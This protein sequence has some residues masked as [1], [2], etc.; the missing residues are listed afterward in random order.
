MII[1][2]V[3]A[4]DK[5]GVIGYQNQLPWHLPADLQHFKR[6]T[7]GKPVVM[8]RKTFESLGKP[9]PGQLNIILSTQAYFTIDHPDCQIFCDL[10]EALASVSAVPEVMV[11]GGAYL[12]ERALP[13]AHKMYLT[14]IDYA[15][16]G[17]VFFPSW[18]EQEWEEV[19]QEQGVSD[20]RNQ[21]PHRFLE[22]RRKVNHLSYESLLKSLTS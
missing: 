5:N 13:L 10:K 18:Q 7:W 14:I 15:F 8:G 11:I 21:Y 3:A 20:E 1:S 12:F 16:H 6:L 9:L 2:L 19:C 4:M 17:D 22:L